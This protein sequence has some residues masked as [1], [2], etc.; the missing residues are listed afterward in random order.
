MDKVQKLSNS[1]VVILVALDV[2]PER[3]IGRLLK[4]SE[5]R[6]LA[7][8]YRWIIFICLSVVHLLTQ[9]RRSTENYCSVLLKASHRKTNPF[10]H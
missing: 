1:V 3:K 7:F 4:R 8:H 5:R 2:M 10:S 6:T 9:R